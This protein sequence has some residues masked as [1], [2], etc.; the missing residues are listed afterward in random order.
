[1]DRLSARHGANFRIQLFGV[2][3]LVLGSPDAVRE[4]FLDRD[5][6]FSSALGWS[7]SIGAL[8]ARGLMLQDFEEHRIDRRIMQLAFRSE[9]MR[10]YVEV[11][12]QQIAQTVRTW[13]L[14]LDLHPAFKQLTLDMAS[15]IFLGLSPDRDSAR[16]NRAFVST[17]AA[18][19]AIVRREV[20]LLAFRRGMRGRR[21]LEHFFSGLIDKRRAAPEQDLLSQLCEA[22]TADGERFS[23]TAIRDHMIFLMMAAHDTTTSSLSSVLHLLLQNPLWQERVRAEI[24]ARGPAPLSWDDRDALPVLDRC[25][26]EAIRLFPPAPFIPRRTIRA[27]T[28]A[29][30]DVPANTSIASC[31]LITHRLPHYWSAPER[32]DPDRFLPERAEHAAHPQLYY[33]FGGGAH[34]CLGLH[35]ARIQVKAVLNELFGRYRVR[36]A[37]PRR[38]RSFAAVPIPYPRDGLPVILEN[39]RA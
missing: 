35:F 2:P 23:D 28:L 1:M 27:C 17:V 19:V 22:K 20:P 16:V 38:A 13:P 32:F 31:A 4:V 34:I 8:F 29:G 24:H 25:F 6:N 11:M 14:K 36:D 37:K 9:A 7:P 12:N 10:A 39:L 3:F 33:P 30:L 5:K 21:V 15:R 18:S 26:D